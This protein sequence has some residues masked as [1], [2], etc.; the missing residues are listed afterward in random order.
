[1]KNS[2]LTFVVCLL[3]SAACVQVEP[4]PDFDRARRLIEETTG[5]EADS[6]ELSPEEID[7]VL[8]DGLT[9][10]EALTLA[11]TQNRELQADFQQIGIGH[12]D[13]V[14]SRL[15]SN[16]SL[17]VLYR[18]PSGSGQDLFEVILG[19]ELLELWRVPKAKEASRA[20]LEATVLRIARVAAERLAD[21][22]NSY[23]AAVAA[24]DLEALAL[25][26]LEIAN[27]TLAAVEAMQ[28]EGSADAVAVNTARGPAL[29]AN[30]AYRTA[31]IEAA[32]AKR[33]LAARLSLERPVEDVSLTDPLPTSEES[34]FDSEELVQRALASRLDL[35]AIEHSIAA[36]EARL[37]IERREAYGDLSIG[38]S[39]EQPSG[40]GNNTLGAGLSAEIPLFDQ[41]QA[42][43]AR[44]EH[45]LERT[46][47]LRDAARVAI[48]QTVRSNAARFSASRDNLAFYKDEVLAVAQSS[49]DFSEACYEMGKHD[50]LTLLD[51]R[52]RF[53][54]A[55]RSWVTLQLEA[56]TATAEL[57]RSVGSVLESSSA[58]GSN[59]G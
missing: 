49:L 19:F 5:F 45:Q 58:T 36:L 18:V 48:T 33:S 43:I 32:N 29:G 37:A 38:P 46:R 39:F 52:K 20:E 10:E 17:D 13:W 55:R 40:S 4:E 59:D 30:L 26:D 50:L 2:K 16:P 44:V 15:V 11:L 31:Q 34:E 9:L 21:T 14:Q 35:Q 57:E 8:D 53:L 7:A 51:E 12:A 1:M 56:A 42:Q 6:P 22:R 3:V 47:K 25:E 24:S 41:N 23:W 28:A 27:R 54:S